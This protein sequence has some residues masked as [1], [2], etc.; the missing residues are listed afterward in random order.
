MITLFDRKS[1]KSTDKED[2]RFRHV[3]ITSFCYLYL[4]FYLQEINFR[5]TGIPDTYCCSDDGRCR[6]SRRNESHLGRQNSING[7]ILFLSFPDFIVSINNRTIPLPLS[8]RLHNSYFPRRRTS[9]LLL[10]SVAQFNRCF[11]RG[12][13]IPGTGVPQ[14]RPPSS[15]LA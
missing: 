14:T 2:Q 9:D 12:R 8:F 13:P 4:R 10:R 11:P 5:S 15:G 6:L 1:L 7:P 3:W